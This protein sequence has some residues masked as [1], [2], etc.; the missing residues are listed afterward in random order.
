MPEHEPGQPDQERERAQRIEAG[1]LPAAGELAQDHERPEAAGESER[2]VEPE[3]PVP[4]DGDQRA[5]ENRADHEADRRD[6]RVGAHRHTELLA[7]KRVGHD[8]C[9]VGEQES[10]AD[11][12]SH[13]PDD[14][15]DP[16]AREACPERGGGEHEETGDVGIFATE[17]IRQPAGTEHEHRRGDHVDENHPD[18]RQQARVQAALEVRQRDDQ[19]AGVDRGKQHADARARQSPPLVM[20]MVC[21]NTKP[22]GRSRGG[23]RGRHEV[24][25]SA[26]VLSYVNVSLAH[27]FSTRTPPP[28][29]SRRTARSV[30]RPRSACPRRRR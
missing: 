26:E 2:H 9:G 15:L 14:Q 16:A 13:A 27:S 23:A 8:R 25:C 19:R 6:H 5:T 3:D 28:W 20:V 29:R 21:I 1:V 22:T 24:L 17:L 18:Q 30:P 4:G 11:P 12:L 7:R 10:A